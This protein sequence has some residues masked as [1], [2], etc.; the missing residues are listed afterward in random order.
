MVFVEMKGKYGLI[1]NLYIIPE[2]RYTEPV[3]LLRLPRTEKHPGQT[4]LKEAINFIR[5]NGGKEALI[6]LKRGVKP[7]EGCSG[8]KTHTNNKYL[9]NKFIIV[10]LLI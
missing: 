9:T 2:E 3:G 6:N 10:E 8:S 4:L 1:T 7:C 5:K